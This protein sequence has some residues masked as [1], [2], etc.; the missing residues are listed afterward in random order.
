MTPAKTAQEPETDV[1]AAEP[2]AAPRLYEL[3]VLF[4]PPLAPKES[5][6]ADKAVETILQDAGGKPV[7]KDVWG[8]RGLAYRI[9]EGTEAAITIYYYELP[10]AVIKQIDEDLRITPNVLR[11]LIVKPPKD[12]QP[13]PT[14]GRF[15]EWLKEQEVAQETV[16]RDKEEELKKRIITRQKAKTPRPADKADTAVAAPKAD[17]QKISE[18][19]EEIIA[20]DE[21][22]L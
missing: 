7:L 14:A 5:Q 1:A 9:G 2:A 8:R 18:K 19:I 6:A 11:H 22:G 3:C 12:Y 13:V 21:L 4:P 15:D 10:P 16:K 20:D 17:K